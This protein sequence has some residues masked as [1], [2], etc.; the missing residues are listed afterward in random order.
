MHI[1]LEISS[2]LGYGPKNFFYQLTLPS[3]NIVLT[4]IYL[5]SWFSWFGGGV[6]KQKT[7]GK[8]RKQTERLHW[9]MKRKKHEKHR[10]SQTT[11]INIFDFTFYIKIYILNESIVWKKVVHT[12]TLYLQLLR[13]PGCLKRSHDTTK[14]IWICIIV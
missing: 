14:L 6:Q 11:K 4:V 3:T 5:Q 9:K 8:R 12:F 7:L 13:I 1:R 10:Q 2:C